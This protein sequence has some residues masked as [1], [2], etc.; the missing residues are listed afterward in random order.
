[1]SRGGIIHDF[2]F[3]NF[4]RYTVIVAPLCLIVAIR[5]M[6]DGRWLSGTAF[7]VAG[8]VCVAV[9]VR[10]RREIF[11]RRPPPSHHV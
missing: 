6:A 5:N 7:L 2:G 3:R 4:A 8:L 9:A 10:W 11:S 1:M